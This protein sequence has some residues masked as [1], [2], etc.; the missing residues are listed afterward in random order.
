MNLVSKQNH[1]PPSPSTRTCRIL[2]K[3]SRKA[4]SLSSDSETCGVVVL[5]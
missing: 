3:K 2:S 5:K 4:L 1:H